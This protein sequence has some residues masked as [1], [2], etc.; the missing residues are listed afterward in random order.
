MILTESK[1]PQIR[2]QQVTYLENQREGIGN[3]MPL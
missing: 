2:I 1:T 3:D